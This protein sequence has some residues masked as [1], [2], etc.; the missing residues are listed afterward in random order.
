M[1]LIDADFLL[2]ALY[3][4]AKYRGTGVRNILIAASKTVKSCPTIDPEDLRPTMCW[5]MERDG[6]GI[7]S[8]CNR[9]DHIDPLAKFCRYCGA[10][11]EED[12]N[13]AD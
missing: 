2:E 1:R 5:M 8:N 4:M 7:C 9:G 13:E 10:R 6:Y 11:M 12:N 3:E